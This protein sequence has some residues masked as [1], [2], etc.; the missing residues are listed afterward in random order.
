[1]STHI[2][3]NVSLGLRPSDQAL[4]TRIPISQRGRDS[5]RD[6][7]SPYY[8]SE[9]WRFTA[10]QAVMEK[11]WVV[12]LVTKRNKDPETSGPLPQSRECEAEPL[13]TACLC[14]MHG[15]VSRYTRSLKP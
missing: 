8:Q 12:T 7:T 6:P 11:Q 3:S 9:A 14:I 2:S 5:C 15:L 4:A 10:L 1:M 13:G